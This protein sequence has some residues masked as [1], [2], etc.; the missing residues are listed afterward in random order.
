MRHRT[1]TLSAPSPSREPRQRLA[2]PRA[3]ATHKSAV[4]SNLPRQGRRATGAH[5]GA[6]RR[7]AP[8][9][10]A[11]TYDLGVPAEV[12]NRDHALRQGGACAWSNFTLDLGEYTTEAMAY[13]VSASEFEAKLRLARVM[14]RVRAPPRAPHEVLHRVRRRPVVYTST[15]SGN[16][17]SWRSP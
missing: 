11:L 5:G 13:G 1:L 9:R 14:Q 12:Q 4:A 10:G 17:V 3:S 16:G 8:W 6:P 15:P 7:Q 2:W